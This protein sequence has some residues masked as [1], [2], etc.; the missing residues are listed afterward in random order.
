[1]TLGPRQAPLG[2]RGLMEIRTYTTKG[3]PMSRLIN[4]FFS[5]AIHLVLMLPSTEAC[6]GLTVTI[7]NTAGHW[8]AGLGET[9]SNTARNQQH[10]R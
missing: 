4:I 6:Y 2:D 1:M 8:D 5:L 10:V 3:S 9:S 7:N